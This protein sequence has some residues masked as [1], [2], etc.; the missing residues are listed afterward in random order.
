MLWKKTVL[1]KKP[2]LMKPLRKYP[3]I[4]WRE[5]VSLPDLGIERMSRI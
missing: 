5:W 4:G 1:E 3:T 2:K